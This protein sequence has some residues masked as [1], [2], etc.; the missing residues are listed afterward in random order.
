MAIPNQILSQMLMG[1]SGTPMTAPTPSAPAA[2][3]P[4]GL[5]PRMMAQILSLGGLDG[6]QS[7]LERQ[8]GLALALQNPTSGQHSTAAGAA[9]GGL[10][11]MLKSAG[12]TV[13]DYGYTRQREKNQKDADA[14]RAAYSGQVPANLV[15]GQYQ[16]EPGSP[17]ATA[18][19]EGVRQQQSKLGILGMMSGD[20]NLSQLGQGLF[21]DASQAP[22]R[23]LEYQGKKMGLLKTQKEMDEANAPA[24]P[25]LYRMGESLG[26]KG[27]P[28]GM[29]A[30]DLR[31]LI[32]EQQKKYG[33][34]SDERGRS[35][36]LN[37]PHYDQGSLG[38][39]NTK[40]GALTPVTPGTKPLTSN[41]ENQEWGKLSKSIDRFEG[42][43]N[44]NVK[45]QERLQAADRIMAIA[46]N[47]DGTPKNLPGNQMVELAAA[48]AQLITGGHPA[49]STISHLVPSTVG[50]DWAKRMQ[51]LSNNPE[52]TNQ[53]AF[54]KLMIDQAHRE[55]DVV[56]PQ[57]LAGQMRKL[58]QFAGLRKTDKAKFDALLKANG[59]DPT[60]IDDN[61]SEIKPLSPKDQE[62]IAWARDAKNKNDPMAAQILKEHGLSP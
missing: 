6:R 58:P 24:G 3:P 56:R 48:S 50:S 35:A 21:T 15:S 4:G 12:G 47:P 10:G 46:A 33:V 29:K 27:L 59:I 25:E 20:K 5:D 37:A 40:T 1:G 38:V 54:V 13:A 9:L 43:S 45:N 36:A 30:S 7:E 42:R 39:L 51:W 22:E 19:R 28:P 44:L 31:G 49:E 2:P 23:G 41:Q 61:G 55:E 32:S 18:A 52:G 57:I 34:D 16:S 26:L 8:S 14:A 60:T 62:A 11:D 17:E 53:K